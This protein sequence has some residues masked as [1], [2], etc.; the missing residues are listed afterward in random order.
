MSKIRI[1]ELAKE[2]GVDNKVVIDKAKEIGIP[3]RISHSN[4][5]DGDEADQIRRAM[6][7]QAVG[8]PQ[9]SEV[10][11]KSVDKFTGETNTVVERRTGN[12]IR[13]RRKDNEGADG[14]AA[15]A[16]PQNSET[17]DNQHLSIA[18]EPVAEEVIDNEEL[19]AEQLE[20]V[21]EEQDSP[22]TDQI[23]VEESQELPLEAAPVEVPGVVGP[24]DEVKK[25]IGPRILGRIELP[26]K[27]VVKPEVKKTAVTVPGRSAPVLVVV[28]PED[29]AEGKGRESGK[30]RSKKR[31]FSRGDLLDYDGREARRG[32]RAKNLKK[33][34]VNSDGSPQAD[35]N[36][37]KAS[38]RVV[39]VHG[40]ITVGELARQVSLKA[41]E[42]IAKLIELGIMATIN[43]AIDHE[44]ASIIAEEFGFTVES[45]EFD[46]TEI[47]VDVSED[48]NSKLLPR[49]PV[50]TV[51]GHVDHGKTSL[52]DSIRNASVASRE[53]GGITQHIGAYRV[54]LDDG[55][56]VAFIDTPGH[57]AFTQMRSRGAKVTDIV[58][59]VVAADDGV[60][61]QTI[62]AI[63]HAKAAE[64]PI[65]VAIN[66]IDKPGANIDKIKQQLVE[67][68][69]QPEDWGGDTMF[70][71]VSALKATGIKELL[72]GVLLLADMKELR[73]NPDRRAKG[74]VI[75]SRQDKGRGTV[76]TVLVQNGTLRVGDLFVAGHVNGRIRSMSNELGER[77]E[78]AGP[79][80]PVEITGLAEVPEAGDDF[81]VVESEAKAREVSAN[82]Q[83]KRRVSQERALATGPISLE[84]FALRANNQQIAELNVILKADVNGSVEAVRMALENLTT[85]K[86]KVR[87]LHAAVGGVT[88]SDVQLATASK[89]IIVGFNVRAETRAS[90]EAE[91][92]GVQI[93]FYRVIYELIDDVKLA[94]A[95][96]LEPDKR[97]KS[98]GR[99]EVRETFTVS[100]IGTIAGSYVV[101]GV[102][103]RGAFIRL[104]RDNVVVH[105]GKM[106]SLR[107]F[108]DDAREV[109]SGFECGIGIENF[110]DVKMGDIVEAFEIEEVAASID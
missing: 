57:A 88:E 51:M 27:R 98:L 21:V 75:E 100:K 37:M 1:Y 60:M 50:V 17:P 87:V 72:E 42:V 80:T 84:E 24:V 52:L 96:L 36:P 104:L 6:I 81:I 110:N 94:M 28:D 23:E 82:R 33:G 85:A 83:E 38:K 30:K 62:E 79:S 48:D 32:P 15:V 53:H 70:L 49:A 58:I 68:G 69:L 47:L 63:N 59:L 14:N 34:G 16:D 18:Q 11:T 7:R 8:A 45:T 90:G 91:R 55:R 105:E 9:K 74:T 76:A 19:I 64:V 65:V 66:K 77:L 5:L 67:H 3:G 109:A 97:E 39:K 71:P 107:R 12:V 54:V 102:I 46:E 93:R 35:V 40:S 20:T 78:Q 101:D 86:V 44:T 25:T 22:T 92:F 31:E 103:R 10:V 13:R 108:K 43:Q 26:Q 29:D 56:S 73:A 89:A 95:G 106:N 61:P 2:L 99:A 41:G 4:S